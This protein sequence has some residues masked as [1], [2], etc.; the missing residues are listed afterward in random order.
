METTSEMSIL[1][2]L[3]ELLGARPA[4][5][6]AESLATLFE[7]MVQAQGRR[8]RVGPETYNPFDLKTRGQQQGEEQ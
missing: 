3:S 2:Q 6:K 8:R 4:E 7:E 5:I 1:D